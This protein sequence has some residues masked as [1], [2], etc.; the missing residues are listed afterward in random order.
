[1]FCSDQQTATSYSKCWRHRWRGGGG[2][3]CVC[4]VLINRPQPAMVSVGVG[5]GEGGVQLCV[6]CSDQQTATS[7][8]KC[9]HQR[10]MGGGG[11]GGSC[12]CFV[13]I[14]RLQPSLMIVFQNRQ[15]CPTLP[16]G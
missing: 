4:F 11:V 9:W 2:G 15:R 5:G 1:M 12:V 8:S 7:Y 3:S 16:A 10:L 13:L 14:N 6:F